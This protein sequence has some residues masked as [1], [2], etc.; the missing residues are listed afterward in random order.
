MPLL[1]LIGLVLMMGVYI[2]PPLLDLLRQAV[3]FLEARP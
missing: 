2:P 3:H 1:V